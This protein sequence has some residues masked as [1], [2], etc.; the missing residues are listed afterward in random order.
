MRNTPKGSAKNTPRGSVAGSPQT[1]RSRSNSIL[2]MSDLHHSQSLKE[3]TALHSARDHKPSKTGSELNTS[4]GRKSLFAHS[5]TQGDKPSCASS[6]NSPLSP[7]LLSP[8]TGSATGTLKN[9]TSM[10]K[11]LAQPDTV[12]TGTE[13]KLDQDKL[14]EKLIDVLNEDN[15]SSKKEAK[16][17]KKK[18]QSQAA[19]GTKK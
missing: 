13:K 19:S 12:V 9:V 6:I 10:E 1:G 15:K 11:L 8:G 2:S 7:Q 18:S 4:G 16:K 5:K 17:P 3:L 14:Y